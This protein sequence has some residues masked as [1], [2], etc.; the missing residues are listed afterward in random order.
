MAAS[1]LPTIAL[2]T[3]VAAAL[4]VPA[5]APVAQAAAAVEADAVGFVVVREAGSGSASTAQSYLDSLLASLAHTNGWASATGKYFTKRSKA[6]KFIEETKPSFGFM[7]FGAYLGLRKAY[8]L[9]PVAVADASAAGGSQYFVISKNQ[10]TLDAC[11]G[12]TLATNHAK[13][14]KFVDRIVSGDAFDLADFQLVETTRPVQTLKAVIDGEAECALVDDSQVLAMGTVEGG[15]LLRPLWS[16]T[17]MPAVLV[18]T[19][20]SAPAEQVQSFT[21]NIEAMCEG[22]G[23]AACDA[24][25]LKAPRRIEAGAFAAE[26]TAYEG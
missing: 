23:R 3:L 16:S 20:G 11:K 14:A 2:C 9:T 26:Q 17:K 18:V 1:K 4:L 13:D 19:F 7:S 24:A 5:A 21:T 25:G 12:K 10:L 8:D 22:D 15:L 6:K